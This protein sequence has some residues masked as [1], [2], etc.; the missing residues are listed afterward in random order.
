MMARRTFSGMVLAGFAAA[1][2]GCG[3]FGGN[4]FRYKLMVEVETLAGIKSGFAVHE[5]EF[6]KSSVDLGELSPKQ[7]SRLRGEA[8]A[9]DLPD[10]QTLFVLIPDTYA[11]LKMLD[12]AGP[13]GWIEK[14]F[15]VAGGDTPKGPQ[16]FA[17]SSPQNY[18]KGAEYPLFVR[19][20]DIKDPKTVELVMPNDLA[21]S[22]GAGVRLKRFMA[23][24]TDED[25]TVGIER[26]LPSFGPET[27]FDKWRRTIP[28]GDP[29][30][31]SKNSFKSGNL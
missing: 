5:V 24:V 12:P 26:R 9:V 15:R 4:S 1:V 22:F 8:V 25:V 31:I 7:S 29:R 13:E 19:F 27:E 14:A 6:S 16:T 28:F 3:V 23:E 10:G 21:A 11:V 20:K 2:S 17:F 18:G 30:G